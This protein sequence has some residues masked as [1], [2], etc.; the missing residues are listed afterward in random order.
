[1]C[2]PQEEVNCHWENGLEVY[3]QNFYLGLPCESD[4]FDDPDYASLSILLNNGSETY[5]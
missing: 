3:L 5:V 2:Q 1:M 4:C